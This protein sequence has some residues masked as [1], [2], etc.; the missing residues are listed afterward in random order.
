MNLYDGGQDGG[1]Q[2]RYQANPVYATSSC[3]SCAWNLV[4]AVTINCYDMAT[5][6]G[7][8]RRLR[9]KKV[10]S[11]ACDVA[12]PGSGCETRLWPG[13]LPSSLCYSTLLVDNA[14]SGRRLLVPQTNSSLLPGAV[15]LEIGR[16]FRSRRCHDM[17]ICR[18]KMS[19]GISAYLSMQR[20]PQCFHGVELDLEHVCKG[21]ST[22]SMKVRVAMCVSSPCAR[23]DSATTTITWSAKFSLLLRAMRM[24]YMHGIY[25]QSRVTQSV[26]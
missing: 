8:E 2:H 19:G 12:L 3:T 11:E 22:V 15:I 5:R 7:R 20:V 25:L 18:R 16:A 6:S 13:G 9:C 1:S 17:C 14:L 24:K 26:L 23:S 4:C 10:G 21:R